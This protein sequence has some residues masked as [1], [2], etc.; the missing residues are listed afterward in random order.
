[1]TIQC[2]ACSKYFNSSPSRQRRFCSSPC[3]NSTRRITTPEQLEDFE[4]DGSF[5]KLTV[6]ARH[7]LQ[8]GITT[9]PQKTNGWRTG[10]GMALGQSG[11]IT[12][13]RHELMQAK[14]GS[15]V[16]T[17]NINHPY[18]KRTYPE[19]YRV[20]GA[21]RLPDEDTLLPSDPGSIPGSSTRQQRFR[22]AY[23]RGKQEAQARK[24]KLEKDN[25]MRYNQIKAL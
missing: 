18:I 5:V 6:G 4:P 25:R 3:Y 24:A 11:L 15:R 10:E 12:N 1:M 19:I 23:L 22:A 2:Q 20:F 17:Y 13:G 8:G 16:K 9:H 7:T 21:E 14:S